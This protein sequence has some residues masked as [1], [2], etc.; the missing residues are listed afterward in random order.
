MLT[1]EK[2]AT[3]RRKC[4]IFYQRQLYMK[5]QMLSDSFLHSLTEMQV[6]VQCYG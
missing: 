1:E 6:R 2:K 4:L 3:G 5:E